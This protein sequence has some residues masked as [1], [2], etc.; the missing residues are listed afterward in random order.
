MVSPGSQTAGDWGD[1]IAP[2]TIA[3]GGASTNIGVDNVFPSSFTISTST[4][5]FSGGYVG[6]PKT[7]IRSGS[8]G[9]AHQSFES[10]VSLNALSSGADTFYAAIRFQTASQTSAIQSTSNSI[11]IVY[12][13]IYNSGNWSLVSIDNGGTPSTFVDLAV[14]A[15][16]DVPILLRMELD[17]SLSEVR[18]YVNGAYAGRVTT[19]LPTTTATTNGGQ[20]VILRDGF[21]TGGTRTLRI[22]NMKLNYVFD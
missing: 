21:D 13:H 22:H 20:C 16:I 12:S 4:T 8:Y 17:K 3:S 11:A 18:A 2:T 15:S 5:A 10:Y 14:A 1:L 19:N 7:I 9:D 6:L